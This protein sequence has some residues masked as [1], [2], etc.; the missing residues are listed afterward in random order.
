MQT[1]KQQQPSKIYDKSENE[2]SVG[3]RVCLADSVN[4]LLP[5]D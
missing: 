4:R 2:E 1:K 3:L 5:S